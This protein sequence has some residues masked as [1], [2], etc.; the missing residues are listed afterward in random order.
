MSTI[1]KAVEKLERKQ[2]T[3][4]EAHNRPGPAADTLEKAVVK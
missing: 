4:G 2:A 1:E 3:A